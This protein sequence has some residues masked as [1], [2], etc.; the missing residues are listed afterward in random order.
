[1]NILLKCQ[2]TV[3]EEILVAMVSLVFGKSLEG[4]VSKEMV[5]Q[6]EHNAKCKQ[7]LYFFCLGFIQIKL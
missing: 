2:K 6:L 1:M 5:H 3:S 7:G 4:V